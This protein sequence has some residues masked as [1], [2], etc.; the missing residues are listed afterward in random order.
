MGGLG[1]PAP[2]SRAFK[3]QTTGAAAVADVQALQAALERSLFNVLGQ[4]QAAK[5][6][7]ELQI[8]IR[9]Q[10]MRHFWHGQPRPQ[11]LGARGLE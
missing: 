2:A 8:K 4:H 9:L 5:G 10:H 11:A 7:K 1:A 6:G 3:P